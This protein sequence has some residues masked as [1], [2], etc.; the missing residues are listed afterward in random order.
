MKNVLSA[1]CLLLLCAVPLCASGNQDHD[2]YSSGAYDKAIERKLGHRLD[3]N[4]KAIVDA[5][6]LW[7]Q[8]KCDGKWDRE[9]F[10]IAVEKGTEN[11]RN[12]A[13]IAAAKA[14]KF[15]EKLL[16]AL[17]VSAGD[18]VDAVSEWIDTNSERY[19]KGK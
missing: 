1:I 10:D 18:A 3:Q 4:E 12:D 19:D 16:K 2:P 11:C 14:G 9:K 6:Y 8:K 7:Y 17:I 13:M 15:G 5:T